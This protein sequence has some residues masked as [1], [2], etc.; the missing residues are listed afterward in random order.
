MRSVLLRTSDHGFE[1]IEDIQ[2]AEVLA[3]DLLQAFAETPR[4]A[5][6]I[7]WAA[8]RDEAVVVEHLVGIG[9][10]DA[11]ARMAHFLLESG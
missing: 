4:L 1:P 8:S 3:S 9:R 10:R 7:L 6:A 11:D 5:A 2:A